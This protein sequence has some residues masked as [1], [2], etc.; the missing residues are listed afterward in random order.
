MPI[1]YKLEILLMDINDPRYLYQQLGIAR[2]GGHWGACEHAPQ[3]V[4]DY[5]KEF[6]ISRHVRSPMEMV[7]FQQAHQKNTG[8]ISNGTSI[9]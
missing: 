5:F 8:D 9:V 2:I 3:W 4:R 1:I 7:S 6:S